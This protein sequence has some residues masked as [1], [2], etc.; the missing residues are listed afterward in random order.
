MG[1]AMIA[2]KEKKEK[3]QLKVTL[4]E[5]PNMSQHRSASDTQ[6]HLQSAALSTHMQQNA[7]WV[8]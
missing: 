3:N 4:N 7:D 5:T 2:K 1:K 8:R 6:K